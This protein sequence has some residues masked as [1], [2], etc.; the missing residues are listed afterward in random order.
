MHDLLYCGFCLANV[1][2]SFWFISVSLNCAVTKSHELKFRQSLNYVCMVPP[3]APSCCI[4]QTNLQM[5]DV[6]SPPARRGASA[7]RHFRTRSSFWPYRGPIKISWW[8][9]KRFKSYRVDK[10]DNNISLCCRCAGGNELWTITLTALV[11]WDRWSSDS[12]NTRCEPV[13][14]TDKST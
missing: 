13:A 10:R 1:S 8:H 3:M 7:F 2:K 14:Y 11:C 5:S 9:L 12:V 6:I 4:V